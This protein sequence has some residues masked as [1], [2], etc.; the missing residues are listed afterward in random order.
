MLHSSVA[1]HGNRRGRSMIRSTGPSR[2]ARLL[3]VITALAPPLWAAK[4]L[5]PR[6]LGTRAALAGCRQTM[7]GKSMLDNLTFSQRRVHTVGVGVLLSAVMLCA[8]PVFA[9]ELRHVAE[10]LKI[11]SG[12]PISFGPVSL[13][14]ISTT[15]GPGCKFASQSS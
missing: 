5:R 9:Q 1:A 11:T 4:A 3:A 13:T 10:V 8:T 7:G 2:S 15:G 6:K 14:C 12:G